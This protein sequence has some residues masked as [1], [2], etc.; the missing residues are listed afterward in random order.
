MKFTAAGDMLIQRHIPSDY[1][2]F[3][4]IKEQIEKGDAR[5]FNLETT[6]N[7]GEFFGNQYF[8]GSHLRTTPNVLNDA[9][10]FGFN[11]LSFANNHSMDFSHDGLMATKR[12]VDEADFP[13]AGAG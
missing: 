4:N 11:M 2:G 13:N 7:N 1:E 6:L 8:G 5:F 9:R 10:A 12:A 3:E